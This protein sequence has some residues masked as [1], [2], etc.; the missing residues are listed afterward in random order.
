[1]VPDRGIGVAGHVEHERARAHARH[2]LR[3]LRS[4]HAGHDDVGDEQ[5]D[6][7][8]VAAGE[9]DRGRTVGSLQD[10]VPA[11]LQDLGD[12]LADDR[13]VLDEQ[14]RL[15]ARLRRVA[16]GGRCLLFGRR[17]DGRQEDAERR[18]HPRRRRHLDR[19]A[20]LLDDAVH[21]R[22]AQA[23][24]AGLC[25]EERIEQLLA[26]R[27]GHA[28]AR[29]RQAELDVLLVV[30][31]DVRRLDRDRA[32]ARH[33]VAR[34]HR[35]VDDHLLELRRVGTNRRELRLEHRQEL[36]VLADQAA[37]HHVHVG[38]DGIQVEHAR[39]QHL[40]AA[41]GEQLPRQRGGPRGGL[42]DLLGVAAQPR[43]GVAA[44]QKLAVA[45]DRGQQVV[46]V[47]RDAA[48][49]AADRLHLLRLAQLYLQLVLS[50]QVADDGDVPAGPHV[51]R[52]HEVDPPLGAVGTV[53]CDLGLERAK[54]QKA[55]PQIGNR[56]VGKQLVDRQPQRLVVRHA[57]QLGARPVEVDDPPF[58]VRDQ[59]RD[60]GALERRLVQEVRLPLRGQVLDVRD[61]VRRLPVVA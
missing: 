40:P 42:L 46:E 53:Q 49:E 28:D 45:G 24:A 23:R 16:C 52:R 58:V 36:D 20:A 41:E 29:V 47:V 55:A 50:R 51:G 37:E 54:L 21:R 39:L 13:L 15:V 30:D 26:L 12:E 10:G 34:V 4:A 57:E 9:L 43:V 35:E 27:L 5:A 56:L 48:G 61:D 2:R 31:H 8:G 6:V 59:L 7:A 3:D 44:D 33:R 18:A 17:F 25:R 14:D 19:A 11:R 32:A 22:E 60:D 1:M 38:N